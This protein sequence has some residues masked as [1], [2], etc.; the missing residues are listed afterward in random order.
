MDQ[1]QAERMDKKS[2]FNWTWWN[3][4]HAF[5]KWATVGLIQ[6]L[7][8]IVLELQALQCGKLIWR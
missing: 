8:N 3:D 6:G 4:H 7:Q 5:K 1:F 2:D